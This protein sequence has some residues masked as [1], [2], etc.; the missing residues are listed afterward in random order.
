MP[1]EKGFDLLLTT[2]RDCL[3]KTVRDKYFHKK[4]T[5]SSHRTKVACYVQPVVAVE[6]EEGYEILHTSF[7]TTSLCNIMSVNS[8]YELK[9]FVSG[10]VR[11]F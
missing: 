9:N 3:P 7:Q 10:L 4:K 1:G 11:N 5:E 6:K 2:R 8:M